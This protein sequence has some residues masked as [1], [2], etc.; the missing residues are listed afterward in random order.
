MSERRLLTGNAAAAWGARL[1]D[2]DYIP[3]FPITPQ[4]EIIELLATWVAQ[5]QIAARYT[6]MDSEHSML[7]ADYA[8]RAVET[9]IFAL[10][11]AVT[12]AVTHT[13]VPRRK[14]AVE[15]YL[16]GQG[17]Y[18][19]LF[20]PLRNEEAIS[21]IQHQVDCY[22]ATVHETTGAAR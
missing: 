15:E 8:R 17:R 14:I 18:R 7:T 6:T 10:K 16:R 3:A 2:I 12:G 20:E 4:T 1:A 21:R 22:W 13:Y 11:K 9:G 5:G 19:H